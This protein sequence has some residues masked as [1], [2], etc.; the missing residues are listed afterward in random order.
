MAVADNAGRESIIKSFI[1]GIFVVQTNQAHTRTHEVRRAA[2]EDS[3]F[4]V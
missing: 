2:A 1:N 4:T 3:V